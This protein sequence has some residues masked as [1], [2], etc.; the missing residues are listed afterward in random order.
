MLV[1]RNQLCALGDGQIVGMKA[2]RSSPDINRRDRNFS[3]RC[4]NSGNNY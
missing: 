4:N 3:E 2:F 1:L